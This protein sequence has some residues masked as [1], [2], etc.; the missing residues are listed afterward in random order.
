MYEYTKETL[1][2]IKEE[3]IEGIY[4]WEPLLIPGKNI[5]WASKAAQKYIHEEGKSTRNEWANAYL[6]MKDKPYHLLISLISKH[7]RRINKI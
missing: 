5:C 4:Y 6:I 2:K 7:I 3:R 1:I